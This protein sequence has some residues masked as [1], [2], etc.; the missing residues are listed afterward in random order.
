MASLGMEGPYAF[1][2]A[3]I[4][5]VV[6]RKSPGNYALGY[7]KDD[8]TFIVQYV[9]RSDVDVKQELKARLD[10]KYKKFKYSY[11]TSPKAAFEKECRNF[12]D[13]GGSE[14]LHNKNHPDRPSGISWKCPV[15]NIFD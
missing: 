13:F 7:T 15:C 5:E 14:K 12:H 4:D 6:T 2:S 1:T 3:K 11:A 8:G 10:S 9:G